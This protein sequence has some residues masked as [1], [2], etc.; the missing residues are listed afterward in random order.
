GTGSAPARPT[1]CSTRGCRKR[2]RY[3]SPSSHF[4]GNPDSTAPH[5]VPFP[6]RRSVMRSKKPIRTAFV[7]LVGLALASRGSAVD[8]CQLDPLTQTSGYQE[9]FQPTCHNCYEIDVAKKQGANT[10]KQVLDQVKNVEVDIWDTKDAVTGG[11][12]KEWY[13]R[14]NPGTLFQSG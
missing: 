9:I 5:G 3:S 10:F 11:V 6:R 8:F 1:C 7:L 13:V 4:Q 12:A 14:H 2:L